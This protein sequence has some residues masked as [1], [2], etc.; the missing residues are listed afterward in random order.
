MAH[1]HQQSSLLITTRVV[2]RGIGRWATD[3]PHVYHLS[4]EG[5]SVEE[6][7]ALLR[8]RA[9]KGSPAALQALVGHYSG[10]PLALKLIAST[11]HDLYAAD[12]EAFLSDGAWVFDDIRGVLD[13]QFD[14]LSELAR[15]LLI[16]L[17]LN[18]VPI[19]VDDLWHDLVV[20]PSRHEFVEAIRSLKRSSLLQDAAAGETV[21][22]VEHGISL[23][24]WNG[25]QREIYVATVAG[26]EV[27][28][29][30][31]GTDLANCIAFSADGQQ[32]LTDGLGFDMFVYDALTGE[33]GQPLAGHTSDLTY[34]VPSPVSATI[35]SSDGAGVVKLW[36]V[37]SGM[38]LATSQLNGPYL[39][40]N[41][42]GAT[43]LT[44]GQRQTL[45]ALGAVDEPS[46]A[47]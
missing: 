35:A 6:G 25:E 20:R 16:W 34:L 46:T 13:Q 37:A 31:S 18:R 45:L 33:A 39:G 17:A 47:T 43:G 29:N 40:M 11:V 1:G 32:L 14:R 24:A 7:T 30:I 5:L 41:I 4:L 28:Y 19:G 12:A 27:L 42:A 38:L 2:P 36:D 9:V 26:G 3:Y 44:Q 21:P 8:Q 22:G 15:D 23:L 10:N